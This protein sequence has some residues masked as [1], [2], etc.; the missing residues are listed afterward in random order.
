M[1]GIQ[2]PP[3]HCIRP[4]RNEER[5]PPHQC[6]PS[7]VL[8]RCGGTHVGWAERPPRER[9][10]GHKSNATTDAGECGAI[11][12]EAVKLRAHQARASSARFFRG[13][14]SAG[15]MRSNRRVIRGRARR[16][17]SRPCWRTSP[18]RDACGSARAPG[19]AQEGGRAA[20][21]RSR[22]DPE[23]RVPRAGRLPRGAP[24][25]RAG[26]GRA[27]DVH[28]HRGGDR[29]PRLYHRPSGSIWLKRRSSRPRVAPSSCG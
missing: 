2:A 4:T 15:G 26:A 12:P 22:H 5:P 3:N 9:F 8:W 17:C 7:R 23:R 28:H 29:A 21:S 16:P 20:S 14:R 25:E 19:Y 13:N 1:F 10:A 18:V 24:E 11:A 27:D 6:S